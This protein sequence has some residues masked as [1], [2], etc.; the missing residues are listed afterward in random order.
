MSER[1]EITTFTAAA[2]QRIGCGHIIVKGERFFDLV[3]LADEPEPHARAAVAICTVCFQQ[4]Q[5]STP[6][7]RTGRRWAASGQLGAVRRNGRWLVPV[8]ARRP[9]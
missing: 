6:A 9:D 3:F 2:D 8:D 4:Q 5:E 7:S 1:V